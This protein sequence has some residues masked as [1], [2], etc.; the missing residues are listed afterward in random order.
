ME[1]CNGLNKD[2]LKPSFTRPPNLCEEAPLPSLYY[3]LCLFVGTTSKCQVDQNQD[4]YCFKNV[5]AHVFFKSSFLK[6]MRIISYSPPKNLSNGIS[7]TPISVH[8]TPTFKEYMV[9]NQNSNLTHAPSFDHNSCKSGLNEQCK[10][11]LIIY[12]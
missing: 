4:S 12:I 2:N 8:V 3:N 1:V 11:T 7:H 6:N 10:G 5:D 9:K